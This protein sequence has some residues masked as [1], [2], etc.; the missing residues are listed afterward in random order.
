MHRSLYAHKCDWEFDG[1][2]F[3]RLLYNWEDDCEFAHPNFADSKEL[4]FGELTVFDFHP[5]HV[6]L[7]SSNGQEYKKFKEK[8]SGVPLNEINIQTAMAFQNE[9]IGVRSH[10]EK[11]L[12]SG[13]RC[14]RLDEI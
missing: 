4:F 13:Y 10:L 14:L 1:V 2:H 3:E 5:L 8:I 11:I 12:V 7:N 6:F 9:G